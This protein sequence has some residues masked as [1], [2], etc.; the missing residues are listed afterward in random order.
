MANHRVAQ[1]RLSN[2]DHPK[3]DE[4]AEA[5]GSCRRGPASALTTGRRVSA[6][7][8]PEN[9]PDEPARR[10]EATVRPD[11]PEWPPF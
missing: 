11:A 7:G 6:C 4:R 9:N 8:Y 3:A 5:A 10:M 1:H 2:H